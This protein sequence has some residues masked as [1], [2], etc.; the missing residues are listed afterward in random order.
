MPGKKRH[1][2][3]SNSQIM[4]FGFLMV[5]LSGAVLLM[6]PIASKTGTSTNFLDC[7]FTS[8][9]ATCVTGLV[10]AVSYTHLTLPTK[11]IV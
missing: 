2:I 1:K 6:M 3:V 9:S 5:I 8:V 10:V 11:R 7:L 4:A